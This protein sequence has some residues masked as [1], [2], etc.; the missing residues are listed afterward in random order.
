L[1]GVLL[2]AD[3]H[4][5]LILGLDALVFSTVLCACILISYVLRKVGVAETL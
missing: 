5:H 4:E 2:E 1:T 3:A